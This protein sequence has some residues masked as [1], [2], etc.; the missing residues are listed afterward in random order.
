MSALRT[1]LR[2]SKRASLAQAQV[3]R[4]AAAA[5]T[6]RTIHQTALLRSP[7]KDDQDR[8]SLKP[9]SQEYAKGSSDDAVAANEDVAFNPNKTDP[10]VEKDTAA[11]GN[12]GNPLESSPANKEFAKG[13]DVGAQYEKESK[14][15][16]RKSSGHGDAPKDGKVA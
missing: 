9:K 11:E 13:G 5:A 2:A 14:T 8:N 12:E 16:P 1:L 10:D 4:P 6:T 7:Y 15:A 3:Q